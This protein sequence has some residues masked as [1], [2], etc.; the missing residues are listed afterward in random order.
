MRTLSRIL[1]SLLLVSSFALVTASA[2]LTK[3]QLEQL[4][5]FIDGVW[6]FNTG[7]FGFSAADCT[8]LS[9]NAS[10]VYGETCADPTGNFRCD[11][12]TGNFV[13]IGGAGGGDVSFTGTTST[14]QMIARH[15]GT[16][17]KTLGPDYTSGAPTISDTGLVT[18]NNGLTVATGPFIRDEPLVREVCPNGCEFTAFQAAIDDIVDESATKIYTVFIQPGAYSENITLPSFIGLEGA[19]RDGVQLTGAT[20]TIA[21]IAANGLSTSIRNMTIISDGTGQAILYP[22]NQ[23]NT[24]WLSNIRA[25]CTAQTN[26]ATQGCIKWQSQNVG[27]KGEFTLENSLIEFNNAGLLFPDGNVGRRWTR[28]NRF[29]YLTNPTETNGAF[30]IHSLTLATDPTSQWVTVGDYVRIR[31]TSQV[32]ST[33]SV[34]G[35]K[36]ENATPVGDNLIGMVIDVEDLG[37][38]GGGKVYALSHEPLLGVVRCFDCDF[39]V[40]RPN[41]TGVTAAVNTAS[42]ASSDVLLYGGRFRSSNSD[43]SAFDIRQLTGGIVSVDGA[44]YV[45]SSG[46]VSV[47]DTRRAAF[48]ESLGMPNDD[49]PV[50]DATGEMALDTTIAGHQP[51]FQYFD[52]GENMTIPAIDTAE[53]PALDDEIMKYDLGTSKFV[54][55]VDDDVPES[56]DFGAASDLDA[57]GDIV[58]DAVGTNELDLN[59]TPTWTGLHRWDRASGTQAIRLK[60][61]TAAGGSPV[62]IFDITDNDTTSVEMRTTSAGSLQVRND[63]GSVAFSV[64]A[65]A[66]PG[67]KDATIIDGDLIVS[68]AGGLVDNRDLDNVVDL[69]GQLGGTVSTPDVR[70]LRTTTGPTL[71]TMDAVVDGE[72]LR[73]TGSLIDSATCGGGGDGVG[74]DEVL[75]EATGRTKRAQLNF[76]GGGVDCVDNPGATRTDCTIAGGGSSHE[77]LSG[78][79][80]DTTTATVVR[81]DL[82]TGQLATP[83]W[84]RLAL[85]GATTFL[86]SDGTDVAWE[87]IATGDL[88]AAVVL[89]TESPGGDLSGTYAGPLTVA[90]TDCIADTELVD[91]HTVDMT[92]TSRFPRTN[93]ATNL[94]GEMRVPTAAD[95]LFYFDSA[96]R[97]VALG[98]SAGL[99][100]D[101]TN[102]TDLTS[103]GALNGNTVDA[104]ELVDDSVD[105]TELDDTEAPGVSQL[106][107]TDSVTATRFEYLTVGTGLNVGADSL[108][109]D[110]DLA[111]ISGLTATSGNVMFAAGSA[112]TSD[113]SPAI[114]CDDC[115]ADLEAANNDTTQV[116]TT[117]FV[118]QE[119]NGAGGTGLTCATGTCNVD[120]GINIDNSEIVADTVRGNEIADA[121]AGL[122]LTETANVLDLDSEI[123]TR[124][125]SWNLFDP[126]TGDS[127][128][129][130]WAPATAITITRVYCST[131]TGTVTIMPDERVEATPNTQGV[132]VLSAALVCDTGTR[133]SCGSSHP[134]QPCDVDTI[135]NASIDADDPVSWDIDAVSTA[136]FVRVHVEFTVDD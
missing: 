36:I 45:T 20:N 113:P 120:L 74:Y 10:S 53:L 98:D 86:G 131:D 81:G 136:T 31:R 129:I 9:C 97:R 83:K 63:G 70:G 96:E 14:D 89:D 15:N 123:E 25:R 88:P 134:S 30:G 41:S 126:A 5:F 108:D 3:D 130:Q 114:V 100:T 101:F 132:D 6:T 104:A 118:Q 93:T 54:L 102:A 24:S 84:Q 85:G 8:I 99:V 57:A 44:D 11:A 116:S 52:G 72:C 105:T 64:Q 110:A 19:S 133:T 112:W 17:G 34:I 60:G 106:V 50:T 94:R 111:T 28:N 21:T 43:S 23:E 40:S 2:Q 12:S 42:I 46:T 1:L 65:N 51:L 13:L 91:V 37:T 38:N 80:T 71:L 107:A 27:T 62:L 103:G 90:C 26:A 7:L 122:H 135:T 61:T 39:K 92:D 59:I 56:G 76:I 127:G 66:G 68:L 33:A 82:M 78:T 47:I 119:I 121:Y 109:L 124:T 32:G 117:S 79:H 95:G 35:V 4:P 115:T 77:I 22:D 125:K 75:D 16:G 69:A 48:S 67:L 73:R 55:E 87:A 58:T 128:K 18:V 29:E 49:A